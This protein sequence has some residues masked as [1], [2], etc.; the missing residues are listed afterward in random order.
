MIHCTIIG[1][2]GADSELRATAGG[3][4]VLG[5]RVACDH[6][7]G[8]KKST[9]WA[10]VSMWGKRG[11]KLAPMLTKGQR[12][13]VRGELWTE[14]YEGKV[15]VQVR[16]DEVELLGDRPAGDAPRPVPSSSGSDIPF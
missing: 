13:A 4:M 9:T 10:R 1:R 2:L 16:A 14:E 8:E 7:F 12:V 5:F 6:G 11:E 15:S 3:E